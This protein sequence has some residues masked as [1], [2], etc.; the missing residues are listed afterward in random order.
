[1]LEFHVYRGVK[2]QF[3]A[4]RK[5]GIRSQEVERE[6]ELITFPPPQTKTVY[7]HLT[8][9]DRGPTAPRPNGVSNVDNWEAIHV[10]HRESTHQLADYP[11]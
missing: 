6:P 5:T 1:M 10:G 2:L 3:K 9:C 8:K 4:I 11:E 7:T